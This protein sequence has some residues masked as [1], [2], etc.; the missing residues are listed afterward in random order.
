MHTI[1]PYTKTI[2]VTINIRTPQTKVKVVARG[3]RSCDKAVSGGIN[4]FVIVLVDIVK[5]NLT[6][7]IF[8]QIFSRLCG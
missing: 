8:N 7:A 6:L 2:C 4:H 1:V 5:Q 3:Q